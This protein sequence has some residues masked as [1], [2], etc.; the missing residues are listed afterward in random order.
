MALFAAESGRY[1]GIGAGHRDRLRGLDDRA[2]E[3]GFEQPDHGV[4]TRPA[5]TDLAACAGLP[6]LSSIVLPKPSPRRM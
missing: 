1:C 2:V 6:A 4:G 5:G 3:V